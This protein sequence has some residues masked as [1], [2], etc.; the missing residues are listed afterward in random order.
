[1]RQ[2]IS[3]STLLIHP[4]PLFPQERTKLRGYSG[5]KQIAHA[6]L[7]KLITLVSKIMENCAVKMPNPAYW[8]L[9]VERIEC[10]KYTN[11]PECPKRKNLAGSALLLFKVPVPQLHIL[12]LIYIW[13]TIQFY[14]SFLFVHAHIL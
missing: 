8:R 4:S 2:A 9:W 12:Y 11:S 3:V 10:L 1:M 7:K 5:I 13:I 14:I 6:S